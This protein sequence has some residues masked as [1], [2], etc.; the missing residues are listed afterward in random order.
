MES[1]FVA[2]MASALFDESDFEADFGTGGKGH[3][4]KEEEPLCLRSDCVA[5]REDLDRLTSVPLTTIRRDCN[6]I[7][8]V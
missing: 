6:Y 2:E 3:G 7:I 8:R 4:E 1:A 5:A